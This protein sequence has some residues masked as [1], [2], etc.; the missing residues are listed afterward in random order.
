MTAMGRAWAEIRH[1]FC[2]GQFHV[3][4]LC[5]MVVVAVTALGP[6]HRCLVVENCAFRE[7]ARSVAE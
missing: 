1:S 6:P 5:F 7:S 2:T 4:V 3:V